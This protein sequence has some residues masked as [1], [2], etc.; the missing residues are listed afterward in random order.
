MSV[1]EYSINFTQLSKHA[2]TMVANS[3]AKMNKFVMRISDLV[4][5]ERRSAMLIPIMDIFHLMVHAKH[6][7]DQKL[8]QFGRELKKVRTKDGNSSKTRFKVPRQIKFKKKIS[9]KGAFNAPRF[10]KRKVSTPKP[11]EGKGWRSYDE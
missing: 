11:Q 10:S 2:P 6:I 9:N 7:E 3:R 1:K 4:V 5:N 8:K